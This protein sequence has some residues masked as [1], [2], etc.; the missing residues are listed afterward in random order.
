MSERNVAPWLALLMLVGGVGFAAMGGGRGMA[1]EEGRVYYVAPQGD[2]AAPGT[3]ERPFRTVQKG[4]DAAKAGDTVT[5][6]AGVYPERVALKNPG[7]E[8]RP[9]RIVG[10]PAGAA[11]LDGQGL[12]GRGVFDTNGQNHIRITGVTVRN[13]LPRGVG[14]FVRGSQHVT[15]ERC[16][17]ENTQDSGIMVDFS[18]QV[19]V[20]NNE[21]TK[22]CQR[23]GEES[24]S[25]KRS[26]HVTVDR[27]HVH[28]TGHEGIDV[29]EG[30][31]RVRVRGNHVHHVERQGL[32]ADAWDKPTTDIRFENN[33]V[34]DCQFGA[35]ACSE[36]GGPLSDVWFVNNVIHDLKGPGLF[37]ADWGDPKSKHPIRGLHFVNNTV[38]RCG[39]G[40][41]T[42]GWGGGVWF[43]NAEAEGVVV[44][45]NLLS[46]N[47]GGQ[48]IVQGGK[49]PKSWT[50]ENNLL[51]G[52]G[53]VHGEKDVTGDPLLGDDLRPGAGSPAI[54]RGTTQDA[55][56]TDFN[57]RPR[58][59]RPDI[60]AYEFRR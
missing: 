21:V 1:E 12:D 58:V 49:R 31:S 9:L 38:V 39:P 7:E 19:S 56:K 35:G 50:V 13:A 51:D 20:A 17:T 48:L 14:I 40:G 4:A 5:L 57:G 23:G 6:L 52:P 54:D 45:N 16:R 10:E 44:R 29:K 42:G 3:K 55:P 27:N 26:K 46:R 25:I 34:H 8:G 32:Y 36:T 18:E 15:V 33:H 22:A 47:H 11:V 24:V 28:H 37:V 2:D 53:E 30:A 43:E 59:G 60:G 41:A